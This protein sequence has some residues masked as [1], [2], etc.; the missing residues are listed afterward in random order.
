MVNESASLDRANL[1]ATAL[2]VSPLGIGT[3][4]WGDRIVWGYQKNSDADIQLA[5]D[6]SRAAGINFFDTAEL[7]GFGQSEK[8]LNRFIHASSN[9]GAE[10]VVIATKCI[11]LP[12]RF[13][14][15]N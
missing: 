6:A 5:F 13:G 8:L 12:W 2:R 10:P 4:A 3:W 14:K 7:Y 11:P 15:R 9:P 1:G